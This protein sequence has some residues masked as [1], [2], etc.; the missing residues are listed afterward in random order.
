MNNAQQSPSALIPLANRPHQV[1]S[2]RETVQE[3]VWYNATDRDIC[4][5]LYV[6]RGATLPNPKHLGRQLTKDE[7]NAT[8][9]YVIEAKRARTIPS[10]F[11]AA[12]QR[13]QCLEA[14]CSQRPL[15]CKDQ[16][17][18]WLIVGGLAPDGL[19]RRGLQH[20]PV[21]AS[22]LDDSLARENAAKDKAINAMV[23]RSASDEELAAAKEEL[24]RVKS[25]KLKLEEAL[26]LRDEQEQ[27]ARAADVATR[28][29]VGEIE[30]AEKPENSPPPRR[31]RQE[32]QNS[33]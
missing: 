33:K 30:S 15:A 21:L 7:K 28:A 12:I 8:V 25:E 10:E 2:P 26:A 24:A 20:R 23:T 29:K 22:G 19:Q 18:R 17:H 9:T 3:T 1:A 5:E 32:V 13:T 11:D 16:T 4:L 31:T 14:E 27:L 6:G